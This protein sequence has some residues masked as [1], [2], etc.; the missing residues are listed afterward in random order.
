MLYD[1]THNPPRLITPD[2]AADNDYTRAFIRKTHPKTIER[3]N[4][5]VRDAIQATVDAG[6]GKL[7]FTKSAIEFGHQSKKPHK[8]VEHLW[9]SVISAVGDGKECLILVGCLLKVDIASR[10]E[11]WL[12]YRRDTGNLDPVTQKPVFV[13]EYWITNTFTPPPPKR[14]PT[15]LDLSTKWGASSYA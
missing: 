8:D 6:V 7:V 3:V 15:V 1:V 10:S 9:K 2:Q 12:V 11:T 4:K 5:T 13:S 14:K